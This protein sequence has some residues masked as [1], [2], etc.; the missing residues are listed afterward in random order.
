MAISDRINLWDALSPKA[1]RRSFSSRP[2]GLSLLWQP[3]P[4][5]CGKGLPGRQSRARQKGRGR[6]GTEAP[7]KI[8]V[9]GG[10]KEVA[11]RDEKI[12]SFPPDRRHIKRRRRRMNRGFPGKGA[13]RSPPG[14]KGTEKS[15]AAKTDSRIAV[16]PSSPGLYSTRRRGRFNAAYGTVPPPPGV[17]VPGRPASRACSRPDRRSRP[18]AKIEAVSHDLKSGKDGK[19][20]ADKDERRTLR[21]HLS[22]PFFHGG[23]LA[24]RARRPYL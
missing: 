18:S 22:A 21:S 3:A 2:W 24:F 11:K 1:N 16:S 20:D 12:A 23:D 17:P 7:G 10:E 14:E 8:H 19:G 4:T 9:H 13:I 6:P 5:G 15:T